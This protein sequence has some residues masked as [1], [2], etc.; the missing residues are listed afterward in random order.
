[1]TDRDLRTVS[2]NRCALVIDDEKD[3]AALAG[4]YLLKSGFEV[5]F[6]YSGRAGIR[7]ALSMKPD[8]IVLDLMMPGMTGFEV[9]ESL[10][11][12]P[13]GEE[14]PVVVFTSS[15]S[16]RNRKKCI[17]LGAADFLDK[18]IPESVFSGKIRNLLKGIQ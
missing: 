16:E 2:E 12:T 9:L 6:A 15:Y 11:S 10:K 4:R 8:I 3:I 18:D 14:I 5:S 13:A 7:K 1:M 17:L